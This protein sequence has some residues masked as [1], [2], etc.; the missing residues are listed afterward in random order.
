M[1]AFPVAIFIG[2]DPKSAPAT[3]I[4]TLVTPYDT[5]RI[6]ETGNHEPVSMDCEI[7]DR[8]LLYNATR[9]RWPIRVQDDHGATRFYGFITEPRITAEGPYA[10]I[11]ASAKDVTTLLDTCI[12]DTPGGY[13][14]TVNESDKSRIQWLLS[15][16]GPKDPFAINANSSVT[17]VLDATLGDQNFPFGQTLRR[18]IER[19]LSAASDSS[20][21]Y[22]ISYTGPAGSDGLFLHTFDDNNADSGLP[23]APYDI[24]AKH[25]PNAGASPPEITPTDFQFSWVTDNLFNKVAITAPKGLSNVFTDKAPF[26]LTTYGQ[27]PGPFSV[28]IFGELAYEMSA[29]DATTALQVQR[30]GRSM[31]RDTRNPTPHATFTLEADYCARNGIRWQAGQTVYITSAMHNLVG[32]NTETGVPWAGNR[33]PGQ[34]GALMPIRIVRLTTSWRSGTGSARMEFE[35]GSRRRSLYGATTSGV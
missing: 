15:T 8:S 11:N 35:C 3:N 2:T 19:V 22:Y 14:R 10:R 7:L 13:K 23:A 34:V 17:Q 30:L 6:E 25:Q 32:R 27:L 33:V 28:D 16:Y 21:N 29:P 12:I 9:G 5:L 1:A 20:P 26:N 31:L 18:A 4:T 24:N